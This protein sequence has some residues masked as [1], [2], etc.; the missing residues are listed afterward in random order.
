MVQGTSF[1]FHD[2]YCKETKNMLMDVGLSWFGWF[3]KMMVVTIS[4]IR[5]WYYNDKLATLDI[6]IMV[7][8]GQ[9]NGVVI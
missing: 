4:S 2:Y 1:S 8:S 9:K 5:S 3:Y 6:W 7:N